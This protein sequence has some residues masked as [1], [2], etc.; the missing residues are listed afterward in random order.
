VLLGVGPDGHVLSVFPGS[1]AFD[2]TE[3]ALGIPAP[4]HVAPHVP[5]VTMNPAVI[6]AARNVVLV[7]TGAA[8]ADILAQ[9]LLQDGGPDGHRELPARIA[10]HERATWILDAA[11]ATGLA[12]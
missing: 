4:T 6:A 10:R 1:V 2:S 11:A 7:A 12:R 9:I 3:W 8:K 5:R